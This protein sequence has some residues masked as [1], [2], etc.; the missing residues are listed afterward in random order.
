MDDL[1]RHIVY[2]VV[3]CVSFIDHDMHVVAE[4]YRKE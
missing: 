2:S 1:F 3:H 4:H